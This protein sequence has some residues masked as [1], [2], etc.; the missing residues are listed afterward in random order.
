MISF[1]T[2]SASEPFKEARHLAGHTSAHLLKRQCKQENRAT[3]TSVHPAVVDHRFGRIAQEVC[4]KSSPRMMRSSRQPTFS[5]PSM[6][7]SRPL[8]V[9]GARMP[10]TRGSDWDLGIPRSTDHGNRSVETKCHATLSA[11]G[12]RMGLRSGAL[13]LSPGFPRLTP[14]CLAVSAGRCVPEIA[15]D[16]QSAFPPPTT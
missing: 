9:F 14:W 4:C 1:E 2:S 15:R 7:I 8:Q 13:E 5:Q 16:D 10:C 11:N 12:A 6:F 3:D